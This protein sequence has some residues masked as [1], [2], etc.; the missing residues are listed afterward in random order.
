MINRQSTVSVCRSGRGFTLIELLVVIAIISLLVSILLPS[1]N[2]A[3]ELARQVVCMS[4]LKHIGLAF[5]MYTGE[6][7]LWFPPHREENPVTE[8]WHTNYIAPYLG[9][10]AKYYNLPNQPIYSCPSDSLFANTLPAA[11]PDP[12]KEASYGYNYQ[13]LGNFN[14]GLYYKTSDVTHPVETILVAD[15]SHY[16]ENARSRGYVIAQT[17]IYGAPIFARHDTGANILWVDSH[18]TYEMDI[19]DINDFPDLWDR[20]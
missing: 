2:R 16:C 17:D 12:S 15:S 6:N 11:Y 13:Y 18:V 19:N 9:Y 10:E 8:A 5:C 1:L 20:D 14:M 7:E 3:K 4:N